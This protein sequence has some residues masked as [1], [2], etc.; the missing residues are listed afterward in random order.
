MTQTATEFELPQKH[1]EAAEPAAQRAK[2][3]KKRHLGRYLLKRL[4]FVIP[5][6][7]GITFI[8]F[9]SIRL[10]PG[11][12]ARLIAGP[13][14][15][16]AT[17][18]QITSDLGLDRPLIVQYFI[19]LGDLLQG[20]LGTSYLTKAP[21][22]DDIIKRLPATLELL[23]ASLFI[24]FTAGVVI[25]AYLAFHRGSLVDRV[26]SIYLKMAGAI[27]EFWLGLLLIYI[28]FVKLGIAPAPLG[29]IDP[30]VDPPREIT[31]SYVIDSLITGNW[32]AFRSSLARL[33]LPVV[34]F[35]LVLTAPFMK[36]TRQTMT[37]VLN[38]DYMRLGSAMGLRKPTIWRNSLKNSL[39]PV[40][41][42]LGFL[43][44]YSLGGAVLI[45]SV[46]AWGGMGQYA[47]SSIVSSNYAAVQAFVLV[48][49]LISLVVY[50]LVDLAYMALDPRLST[51]R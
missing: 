50:L 5:Q 39:P 45:E 40:I 47:V 25:G 8:T 3:G 23:I 14:A 13:N 38:S 26:L 48:S 10:I 6:L 2:P 36:M 42:L 11:D 17:L 20:D 12:P 15:T 32:T 30:L 49:A 37:E 31:R 34:T 4:L 43:C 35:S 16:E 51:S 29:R 7:I 19:Y 1:S 22:A 18:A 21:V 41:T 24:A 9:V 44:S 28:F 46:F 33:I 27:P